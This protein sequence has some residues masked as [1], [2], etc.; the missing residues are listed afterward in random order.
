MPQKRSLTRKPKA[1]AKAI[2]VWRFHDAPEQFRKLSTHGGDE[3]WLAL[4]PKEL[5]GQYIHWLE[6]PAFGCCEVT[7]YKLEGGCIVRIGAHS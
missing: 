6:E 3:D 2:M 7:E 4:V 1:Q 5:A